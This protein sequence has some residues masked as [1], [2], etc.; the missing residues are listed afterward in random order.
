MAGVNRDHRRVDPA[1]VRTLSFFLSVSSIDRRFCSGLLLRADEQK[2][3]KRQRSA[4]EDESRPETP[5]V[6]VLRKTIGR[7]A[8][9]SFIAMIHPNTVA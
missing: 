7:Y 4:Q 9:N 3:K 2:V 5:A 6:R 8:D 1:V